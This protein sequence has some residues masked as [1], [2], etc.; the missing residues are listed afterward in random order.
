MKKDKKS[1]SQKEAPKKK[2]NLKKLPIYVIFGDI[3]TSNFFSNNKF[4]ILTVVALLMFYITIKY[5][6]Q[7]RMETIAKLQKELVI[8]KSESIREQSLFRSRTRESNM[9]QMVDSMH[10]QLTIPDQPPVKLKYNEK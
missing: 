2:L 7:T 8:V 9:K 1:K 6:C 4:T 5:E 10:L 3:I